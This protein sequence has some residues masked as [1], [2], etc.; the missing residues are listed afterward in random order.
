MRLIPATDYKPLAPII[1]VPV[2]EIVQHETAHNI[3]DFDMESVAAGFADPMWVPQK[4]T[5]VAWGWSDEHRVE[6]RSCGPGGIVGPAAKELRREMLAPLLE[7][8]RYADIVTGHNLCRHD[9]P[10]LRAECLRLGLEP[11]NRVWVSDTIKLGKL[12][13]YKKGQD[14]I[15]ALKGVDEQKM[16]L[17][18]QQWDDAYD[19]IGW[20]KIRARCRSD[21]ISHRQIR[22]KLIED[23]SLKRPVRWIA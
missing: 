12:K 16:A 1:R 14:N 23:G 21:V 2:M 20:P 22:L 11:V 4:I 8:I 19:E 13:G 5:C 3:L 9:L 10:L 6:V 18:W 7:A 17:N 15:A